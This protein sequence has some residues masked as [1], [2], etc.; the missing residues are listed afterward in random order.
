[1]KKYLASKEEQ[2]LEMRAAKL[3]YES[4]EITKEEYQEVIDTILTTDT[5]WEQFV[6]HFEDAIGYRTDFATLLE[7]RAWVVQE[8]EFEL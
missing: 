4:K 5:G 6:K 2:V 1:M 8:G 7:E 3:S